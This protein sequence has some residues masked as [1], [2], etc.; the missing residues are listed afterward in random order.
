MGVRLLQQVDLLKD[1]PNP[2][3]VFK[4]KAVGEPSYALAASLHQAVKYAVQSA[5][6]DAG[7]TGTLVAVGVR[8]HGGCVGT[9]PL[10]LGYSRDST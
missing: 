7:V 5:R 8:R 6:D 2:V 4:S 3:G 10:A 1:M 9:F